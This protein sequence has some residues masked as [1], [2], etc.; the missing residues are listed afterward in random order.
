MPTPFDSF[1][2]VICTDLSPYINWQCELLEYSWSRVNQPGNIVRLVAC[3][4]TEELPQHRF[5]EAVR[6]Q[7]TS[8]HPES[9]DY[10]PPYNRLF[11]LQEWLQ[12]KDINGSILIIDA[13]VVFQK[14]LKKLVNPGLPLAQH[15]LDF[16]FSDDFIGSI[17][18]NSDV[19]IDKLRPITWPA[20]IHS[21]DLR[22]M[23]PRWIELT[24][25]IREAIHRQES[26]MYGFVVAAEELNIE[27]ELGLHTAFMPWPDEQV[28]ESPLIHYCQKVWSNNGHDLWNKFDY[29]PWNRVPNGPQAHLSYCRELLKIIDQYAVLKESRELHKKD[30]IFIAIASYCE[31]ELCDTIQSC[32]DKAH[33]PENLTFGICHQF[34]NRDLLTS[35]NCLDR[36]SDDLRVRYV[37]YPFEESTGGCWA[38]NISQT[39]YNDE[40]YTLQIDAHSRMIDGWDVLLMDMMDNLPADKPL[41]TEFPPLYHFD[42]TGDTVFHH[43]E[44]LDQV[45]TH[46]AK[47][48]STDGW[49]HHPQKL[50][51]E[52]SEFPRHTRFLSGAFVFTLGEWNKEVQQDPEHFYTGEEFALTLRSFTK[53]Y[54]LFD[55]NQIALWHRLHPAP[56]RKFKDDNT[57][58]ATLQRH[59]QGV[60]RLNL[61]IDGDPNGLLGEFA[62]GDIKTLE[63]YKNFSGIDCVNRTIS[64]GAQ[65]GVPPRLFWSHSEQTNEGPQLDPIL[66]DVVIHIKDQPELDLLCYAD[67]PVIQLLFQALV[68]KHQNPDQVIY[69]DLGE[70][71]S[72]RL[73]FRQSQLIAVETSPPMSSEFIASIIPAKASDQPIAA[74]HQPAPQPPFRFED[75]WK[76]WIWHNVSRGCSKDDLI[77]ELVTLH[78]FPYEATCNELNHWPSVS[79]EE[80]TLP[81]KYAEASPNLL[82]CGAAHK[83][84][85]PSL[86]IYTIDDFLTAQECRQLIEFMQPRFQAAETVIGDKTPE[87]RTNTTCFFQLEGNHS[88]FSQ[89]ITA[90]IARLVGLNESYAESLQGHCYMPGQEYKAHTDWFEPG[91][92]SFSDHANYHQGGQ[93]TWSAILYLNDVTCGG[94]TDFSEVG[95]SVKPSLGKL[96]FWNNLLPDGRPNPAALHIGTPVIEGKKFILTQWFRTFGSGPMVCQHP[97]EAIQS[98][99]PS[100]ICKTKLDAKVLQ[101]IVDYFR[102]NIE[103]EKIDEFVEGN[104]IVN[105]DEDVGSFLLPL[106]DTLTEPL[107]NEIKSICASWCRVELEHTAIYGIRIYRRGT[108]LQ[109]HRD[110]PHTHIISAILNVEQRVDKDWP[111]AIEDHQ[112]RLHQENL[113]PGELLLYEGARLPH[114]RPSALNGDYYANIFIHFKPKHWQLPDWIDEALN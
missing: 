62:L 57:E 96:V 17:R 113:E 100:G 84:E 73:M 3:E 101:P 110:R 54:E 60:N 1:Y 8:H 11:S 19:V 67:N 14:P 15:W 22:R 65:K 71:G 64:I 70:A 35:E 92:E 111:L 89:K 51:P 12:N 78:N 86:D 59:Q 103:Q 16:G 49:M 28:G 69:L 39:L 36:Y 23:L 48:W 88:T 41:I 43:I 31:P 24:L 45:N 107:I 21:D 104:F 29:N 87:V 108:L 25:R 66:L 40:T 83:L 68:D 94:N 77:K 97:Q 102:N 76:I 47:E 26:D 5:M 44:K 72:N 61:L 99:T 85:N 105:S 56:N 32:L 4:E 46:I 79:L 109:M 80:I 112:C 34:D 98:F 18:A 42:D 82:P 53:G 30:T 58:T 106:P 7:P 81:E 95:L 55:P 37:A 52:N 2:T 27:F 13:D 6:C 20:V 91:T 90:R 10:Y 33:L 9:G 114:G 50:V 74:A 63:D 75:N 93:R 38:R